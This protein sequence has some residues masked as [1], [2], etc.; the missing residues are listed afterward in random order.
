M[1]K[2]RFTFINLRLDLIVLKGKSLIELKSK[3]G[4]KIKFSDLFLIVFNLFFLL[5]LYEFFDAIAMND[6]HECYIGES[7]TVLNSRIDLVGQ[8]FQNYL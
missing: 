2:G 7:I 8:F 6:I 3:R 1:N 4:P 5:F